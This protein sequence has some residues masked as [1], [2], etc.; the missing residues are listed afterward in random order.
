V[1]SKL[2]PQRHA[3]ETSARDQAWERPTQQ[4]PQKSPLQFPANPAKAPSPHFSHDPSNRAIARVYQSPL[5][6]LYLTPDGTDDPSEF[7]PQSR[8]LMFAD[9]ALIHA[10]EEQKRIKAKIRPHVER[11]KRITGNKK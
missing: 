9:I 2:T 10:R 4:D 7:L 8:W 11:Y 1:A 3:W 6:D 5:S